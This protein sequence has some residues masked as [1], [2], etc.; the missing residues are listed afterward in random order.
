[1]KI[2]TASWTLTG[3]AEL[4]LKMCRGVILEQK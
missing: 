3:Q 4:Q 1:M 2:F